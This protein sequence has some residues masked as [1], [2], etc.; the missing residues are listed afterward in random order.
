MDCS[1]EF[2]SA[3]LDG[4]SWFGGVGH[5]ANEGSLLV[6]EIRDGVIV[7]QAMSIPPVAS[8]LFARTGEFSMD[9]ASIKPSRRTI[10]VE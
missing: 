4:G 6:L 10:C 8:T 9:A 7:L 3:R 2:V 5:L 1:L